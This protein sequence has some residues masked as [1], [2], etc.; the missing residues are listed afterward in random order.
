MKKLIALM[1]CLA[2]MATVARAE[3]PQ[4]A[5]EK[6]N[7]M[8]QAVDQQV[9]AAQRT[10][11]L[12]ISAVG[13]EN[14]DALGKAVL[15]GFTNNYKQMVLMATRDLNNDVVS[16]GADELVGAVVNGPLKAAGA[17]DYR[18]V[19]LNGANLIKITMSVK[20]QGRNLAKAK[21]F[22]MITDAQAVNMAQKLQG[23]DDKA[24]EEYRK[25]IIDT[26][27]RK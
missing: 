3:Y 23:K 2:V 22:A 1:F 21:E 11:V 9:N 17:V 16:L 24:T 26:G 27:R 20:L 12:K 13:Y 6:A 5:P 15:M 10:T 4:Q 7:A 18:H 14:T 25:G 19:N 8:Q